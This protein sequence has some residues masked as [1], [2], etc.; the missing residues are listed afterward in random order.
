MVVSADNLCPAFC[1]CDMNKVGMCADSL[2]C[3]LCLW[4]EQGRH[5]WQK[6]CH[7]TT[8]FCSLLVK[9]KP[10]WPGP[11]ELSTLPQQTNEWIH[12]TSLGSP[13]VH[14][15][16]CASRLLF[17]PCHDCGGS[18]ELRLLL[19]EQ[20][21]D[22]IPPNA[23][24]AT[25]TVTVTHVNDPPVA[26]AFHNGTD[27]VPADPAADIVVGCCPC[28]SCFSS[29]I[30]LTLWWVVVVLVTPV[31]LLSFCCHCSFFFF[32]FFSFIP[33]G[34][35]GDKNRSLSYS[36]PSLIP[37]LVQSSSCC[38]AVVG[39]WECV[40]DCCCLAIVVLT[41]CQETDKALPTLTDK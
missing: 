12:Q 16:L 13:H 40:R 26:F 9:N 29:F 15:F 23:A 37:P 39:S 17:T 2:S 32:L 35:Q 30:L 28:Y 8:A 6:S 24:S 31:S 11:V 22:G 25:V 4:H 34:W 21:V 18:Y 7:E 3:I 27:L 33:D 36:L 41:S 10:T 20:A 38:A 5:V 19:A 1:F 14:C